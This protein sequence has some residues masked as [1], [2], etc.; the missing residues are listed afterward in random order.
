MKTSGVVGAGVE[1]LA[2]YGW[3]QV[4]EVRSETGE[5]RPSPVVRLHPDF[6]GEVGKG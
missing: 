4:A 1:L 2:E 3:L 5:G 6:H